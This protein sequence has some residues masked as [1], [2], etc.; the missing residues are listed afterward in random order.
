MLAHTYLLRMPPPTWLVLLPSKYHMFATVRQSYTQ[1]PFAPPVCVPACANGGECT[2]PGVCL[3]PPTH[4][5][6][7]CTV[8]NCLGPLPWVEGGLLGDQ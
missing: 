7:A 4:S 2:C 8:R 5:G 3:C 6:P 1:S